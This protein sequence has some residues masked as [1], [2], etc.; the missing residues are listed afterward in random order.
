MP[1][2]IEKAATQVMG[3]AKGAMATV[4]GLS[5]VF[6][7]LSREHGELAALL[8][9][10]TM[11]TEPAVRSEFFPSIR[12]DLLSHEK[13]ELAEVYSVFRRHPDLVA[14]AEM[15]EREAATLERTVERLSLIPY[16]DDR[17]GP[18]F[19]D[20]VNAVEHHIREEEGEFFPQA[21]RILGKQAA[22]DMLPRYEAA[23]D[24]ALQSR[25]H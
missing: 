23:R 6:K 1:S 3:A 17:W 2:R 20:L 12:E 7:Q 18:I 13:G 9:R 16:D 11:T 5:G 24:A 14:Y 4:E 25:R 21:N 8:A 19:G 10:V 22:E 15:H